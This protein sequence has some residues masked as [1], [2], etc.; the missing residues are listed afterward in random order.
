MWAFRRTARNQQSRY[1]RLLVLTGYR[2]GRAL[3]LRESSEG[4]RSIVLMAL[5]QVRHLLG[6]WQ[7]RGFN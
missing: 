1:L 2:R 3:W 6:G 7:A 4:V 5:T